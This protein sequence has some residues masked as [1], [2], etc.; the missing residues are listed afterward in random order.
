MRN[1]TLTAAAIAGLS[2]FLMGCGAEEAKPAKTDKKPAAEGKTEEGKTVA[3]IDYKCG[4]GK[5][6]KAKKG[7]DAPQC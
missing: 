2:L 7:A 1:I 5:T 6:A 4:C 3:D